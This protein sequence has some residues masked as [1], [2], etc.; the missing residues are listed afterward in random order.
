[1]ALTGFNPE[2]VK[3]S[4]N[5]INSAFSSLM[6]AIQADMQSEFVGGMADKW[7]C[8]QA[9]DFF[10][11]YKGIMNTLINKSNDVFKSVVDSMNSAAQ[12]W[13][14]STNSEFSKITFTE[15]KTQITVDSIKENINGVRGIDLQAATTVAAKLNTI[16]QSAEGALTNAQR[17]VDTCGFIGGNQATNLVNA[18]GTVKKNINDAVRTISDDAK[19][20][21][22]NTVTA[23][24]DTEGKVSSAFNGQ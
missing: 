6:Q 21:I 11:E 18:L 8:K 5:A 24:T 20:A 3:T 4:I 1:M 10:N 23:Y 19:K 17:A 7:A 2:E 14:Q 22:D 16:A 12:A 9:Q 15:K 13:A